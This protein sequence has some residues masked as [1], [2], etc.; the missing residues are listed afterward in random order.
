MRTKANS[1]E[2]PS[3]LQKTYDMLSNEE[4]FDIVSWTQDGTAFVI[5]DK[6]EF[7]LS[8]LPKYF[9]HSN[10]AS[11]VRQLNMYDFHKVRRSGSEDIFK[12]PL[13]VRHNPEFLKE[14]KRK[15][16]PVN[17]PVVP[18]NTL[19]KPELAPILKRMMDLHISNQE[20]EHM[21]KKLEEKVEEL[22]SQKQAL[23]MQFWETQERMKQIE[24]AIVILA[25][26]IRSDG[27]EIARYI[28][29]EMPGR[30]K[31]IENDIPAPVKKRKLEQL[32]V[33]ELLE[34]PKDQVKNT[35]TPKNMM[36]NHVPDIFEVNSDESL[37]FLLES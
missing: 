27:G 17:W 24:Q 28:K 31:S 35:E 16:S 32:S 37:E 1:S 12:H 23:T 14:I 15:T 10:L 33:E 29:N 19:S 18:S 11:F 26:F 4:N 34:I 8:I 25:G 30:L 3:F 21:I 36:E 2:A 9:K 7:C 6:K 20:S 13:F 5:K 22:T